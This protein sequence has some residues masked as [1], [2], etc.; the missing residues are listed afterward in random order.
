MTRELWRTLVGG[1]RLLKGC[2]LR[3]SKLAFILRVELFDYVVDGGEISE[4]LA[5]RNQMGDMASKWGEG[6]NPQD[7]MLVLSQA[8]L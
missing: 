8:H 7:A 3:L 5:G 1:R 4:S 2:C 6:S